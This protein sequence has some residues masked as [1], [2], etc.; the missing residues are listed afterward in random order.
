VW[1][2][3]VGVMCAT[4]LMVSR[5]PQRRPARR[6]LLAFGVVGTVRHSHGATAS[7]GIHSHG[8]DVLLIYAMAARTMLPSFVTRS[9][10]RDGLVETP[11]ALRERAEQAR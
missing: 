6:E 5:P 10:E 11:K 1:T 7:D 4:G 2:L 9:A 8:C 3:L